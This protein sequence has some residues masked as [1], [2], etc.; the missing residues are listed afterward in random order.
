M[1]ILFNVCKM[2]YFASMGD[3]DKLLFKFHG[4]LDCFG[5]NNFY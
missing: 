5:I 4:N 1:K 2:Y 3:D